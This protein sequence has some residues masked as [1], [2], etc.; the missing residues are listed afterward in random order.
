VYLKTDKYAI[1]KLYSLN[2]YHIN[3]VTYTQTILIFTVNILS[4]KFPKLKYKLIEM[5][6][7][8]SKLVT[9]VL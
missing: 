7:Q 6:P 3:T 8:R 4:T 2:N 1:K 9:N 5:R